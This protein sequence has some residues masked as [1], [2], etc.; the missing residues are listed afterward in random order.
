MSDPVFKSLS[1]EDQT[2]ESDP[3]SDALLPKRADSRVSIWAGLAG[4]LIIHMLGL[5]IIPDSLLYV[6]PSEIQ[7]PYKD[8]QIELMDPEEPEEP[9]PTYTQTNPDAPDNEPDETNRFAARNQQ[10]AQEELPDE[11]D[12]NERPSS[13]S[14]DPKETDQFITGDLSPPDFSPPPS[15]S[16]K[17]PQEEQQAVPEVL[18]APPI[19]PLRK[20]VPISG[21]LEDTDPDEIG[22]A[23]TDF[24]KTEDVPT[25]VDQQIDGEVEEGERDE[26]LQSP[27][28]LITAVPPSESVTSDSP[29][30]RPRPKMPRVAPGPVRNK[31]P[32]VSRTG[33]IG[34]D[35]KFSEFGEYMER[36]IETVSVRWNALARDGAKMENNS[37]V[38]ISFVLHSSGSVT[39]I[40]LEDSTAKAIGIY[41]CRSAI[42]LGSPYAPWTEEMITTFG[43][44]EEITFT[45]YYH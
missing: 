45:F 23:E 11:L 38:K 24:E 19:A 36:L 30:P 16:Q 35:A 10:A 2:R 12:P 39:N 8:Y 28:P 13:E 29:S 25:N 15:E 33:S 20:E 27:Q 14:D 6:E 43:D 17:E 44:S 3:L 34:V 41:M 42:A 18:P 22:I 26:M 5:L 7:N 32:G 31:A 1:K 21:S 4:T 40:D 9:D 37:H